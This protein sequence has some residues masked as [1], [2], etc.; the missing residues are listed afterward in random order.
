M[1]VLVA[2]EQESDLNSRF[3]RDSELGW[4][5]V[6]GNAGTISFFRLAR[7]PRDRAAIGGPDLSGGHV[8][9][10]TACVV[11]RRRADGSSDG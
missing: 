11:V 1:V 8:V 5:R 9:A 2:N 3:V 10:A 4:G 7:E 6:N